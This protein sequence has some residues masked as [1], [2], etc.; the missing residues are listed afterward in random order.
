MDEEQDLFSEKTSKGLSIKEI[1]LKYL[2]H[3]PLFIISLVV[4]MGVAFLYL[5]YTVPKYKAS[6]LIMVKGNQPSASQ[7]QEQT[8]QRGK[9]T[10]LRTLQVM[11]QWFDHR[12]V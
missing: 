3:F 5:R 9:G 11:R 8:H 10:Q 4:C 6:T 1:V 12:L 2:S 7:Q